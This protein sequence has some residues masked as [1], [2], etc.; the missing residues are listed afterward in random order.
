MTNS[1][2]NI[3]QIRNSFGLWSTW[4]VA[5]K[6]DAATD[7][8]ATPHAD[9]R[10]LTYGSHIAPV[11]APTNMDL[12]KTADMLMRRSGNHNDRVIFDFVLRSPGVYEL[13]CI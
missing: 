1:N 7:W 2:T 4:R 9:M 3:D 10:V 6:N 12:W 5:Q 11:F 8:S 13:R